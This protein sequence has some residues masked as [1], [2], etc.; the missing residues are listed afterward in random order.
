M[1]LSWSDANSQSPT[2]DYQGSGSFQHLVVRYAVLFSTSY[3]MLYML[4][5][6]DALA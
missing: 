2:S 4:C 6:R 5:K 3:I 1:F